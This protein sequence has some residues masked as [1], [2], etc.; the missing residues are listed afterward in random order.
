MWQD[1]RLDRHPMS[2]TNATPRLV[3]TDQ[4][5]REYAVTQS[6]DHEPSLQRLPDRKYNGLGCHHS[7]VEQ[8]HPEGS[9]RPSTSQ[10][11]LMARPSGHQHPREGA[12]TGLFGR[13]IRQLARDVTS[14][15]RQT[16]I[17]LGFRCLHTN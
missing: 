14:S 5:A 6:Q 4:E 1:T 17:Q 7:H 12:D 15:Y 11:L 2:A 8:L 9:L 16:P 13:L 3:P 10:S